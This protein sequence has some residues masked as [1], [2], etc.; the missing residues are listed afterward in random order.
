MRVIAF[1]T[2]SRERARE[3]SKNEADAN[4]LIR[5]ALWG[6]AMDQFESSPIVGIGRFRVNDRDLEFRGTEGLVWVATGGDRFHND[7][8]PHN[9]LLYL[10]AETGVVGLLA[11]ATPFVFAWRWTRR[12]PNG[13]AGDEQWRM[14][15]RVSL[16]YA[17]IVG[18][19]SSGTM[20]TG[21]GLIT[22]V[23]YFGAARAYALEPADAL[24]DVGV[25]VGQP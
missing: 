12:R 22:A 11:Y 21:L 10:L 24:H 19:V 3:L 16:L 25:E 9:Q 18:L 4:I 1:T 6:Q 13:A 20:G 5:F 17:V 15:S 23:L 7:D 14:L 2:G 8:E